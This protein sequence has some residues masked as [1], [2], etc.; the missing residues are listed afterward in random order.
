MSGDFVLCCCL[1]F[2][3]PLKAVLPLDLDHVLGLVCHWGVNIPSSWITK[4]VTLMRLPDLSLTDSTCHP[5]HICH[6]LQAGQEQLSLALLSVWIVP[7]SVALLL[8][9]GIL[10][11]LLQFLLDWSTF[12]SW[13]QIKLQDDKSKPAP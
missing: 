11:L 6:S 7:K 13:H 4:W 8:T 3:F 5:L 12:G 2:F 10:C 1:F 9:F